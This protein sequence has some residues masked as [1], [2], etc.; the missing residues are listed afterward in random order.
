MQ[1]KQ[2]K[3]V[4]K[5]DHGRNCRQHDPDEHDVR[6][7][8]V[9]L[10]DDPRRPDGESACHQHEDG[11]NENEKH[12]ELPLA[13]FL[14]NQVSRRLRGSDPRTAFL[15]AAAFRQANRSF[16]WAPGEARP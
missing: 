15:Q 3:I 10:A 12:D 8:D 2:M 13:T 16:T 14:M 9:R 7:R 5:G 1:M 6:I 4:V 11:P